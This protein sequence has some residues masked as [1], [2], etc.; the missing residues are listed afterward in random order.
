ME[1][2]FYRFRFVFGELG[3]CTLN[4]SLFFGEIEVHGAM[5][6][7]R[8]S[9]RTTAETA[10]DKLEGFL[11][12]LCNLSDENA[13]PRHQIKSLPGCHSESPIEA[14]NLP[15]KHGVFDYVPNKFRKFHWISQPLR[16][17]RHLA[18]GFAG[19]IR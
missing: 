10:E 15:V 8:L 12:V 17:R 6:S 5:L 1:A 19:R 7:L 4:N 9:H 11:C 18:Q 13:N 2:S 14:D 16:K 3:C